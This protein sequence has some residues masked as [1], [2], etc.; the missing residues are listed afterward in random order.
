MRFP[1]LL[2][3][4]FLLSACAASP[5]A[6]ERFT[7]ACA[8]GTSF[9]VGYDA[10]DELAEVAAGGRRYRLPRARSGSGARYAADG[11]ELWE[12]Q[13]RASLTGAAGG[14]YQDCRA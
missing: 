7:F 11:V 1:L 4:A 3:A 6:P 10:G 5:G 9:T 13:G 12:H 8:G 14:P 2:S